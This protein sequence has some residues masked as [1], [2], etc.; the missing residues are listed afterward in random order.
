MP[1]VPGDIWRVPEGI[2]NRDVGE[3]IGSFIPFLDPT[4]HVVFFED[5]VFRYNAADWVITTTEAGAGSATEALGDG[6]GG[7]L[8]VTNDAAD[9]DADFFNSTG[10]PFRFTSGKKVW[11]EA[12]LKVS[13]AT[14]S[15]VVV[16]LQIT[17]TTPLDVTDGVFFIKSD[18]AATVN[19]HVEKDNTQTSAS[20]VATMANDTYIKLGFTYDGGQTFK[21]YVNGTNVA[22]V[23]TSTTIPDDEDLAISFG[24]QNGEA[25]AK[26]LTVDYLLAVAER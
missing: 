25:V 15:D 21:V 19:F 13:D 20:A 10:E 6:H 2:T 4:K 8:V 23:T 1:F 11:F 3:G 18:G 26:V 24:V 9:D 14:Q 12:R 5:F 7:T 17:D 16:G 22:T